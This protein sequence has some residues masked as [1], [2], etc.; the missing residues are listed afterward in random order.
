MKQNMPERRAGTAL[1]ILS[2]ILVCLLPL[3]T[4]AVFLRVLYM[5]SVPV[6]GLIVP[7]LFLAGSLVQTGCLLSLGLVKAVRKVFRDR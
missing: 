6:W 3:L 7:G 2:V 5:G 1:D 4:G